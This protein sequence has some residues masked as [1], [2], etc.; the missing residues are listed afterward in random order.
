MTTLLI[1]YHHA[2]GFK[3]PDH[4][5]AVSECNHISA[6][7]LAEQINPDTVIG[8]GCGAIYALEVAYRRPTVK[9]V[10][11]VNPTVNHHCTAWAD[12]VV[13]DML[14]ISGSDDTV[15]PQEDV[16]RRLCGHGALGW[17][18][19]QY[20]AVPQYHC[21]ES[22]ERVKVGRRIIR[23]VN[24]HGMPHDV[25]GYEWLIKEEIE[26]WALTNAPNVV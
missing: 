23:A 18:N 7:T 16:F 21:L 13:C 6:L 15:A 12:P 14:V 9:R 3:T 17:L 11:M 4:G 24:V 25:S 26:E 20:T 22:G 10:V 19:R 8:Y 5:C 2:T 1:P